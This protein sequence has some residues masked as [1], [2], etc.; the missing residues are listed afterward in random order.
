MKNFR[1]LITILVVA[2]SVTYQASAQAPGGVLADANHPSGA[3]GAPPASSIWHVDPLTGSLSVTI[4]FT[5]TP[6]GGRGPKIPFALK[7]NSSATVTLQE[8]GLEYVASSGGPDASFEAACITTTP[9]GT[10][11]VLDSS[12]E[13]APPSSSEVIGVYGWRAQPQSSVFGPTGPWITT[14]PFVTQ[15]ETS[16]V[17]QSY[18]VSADSVIETIDTG[19]GCTVAGPF[20]YTDEDGST[21]DMNLELQGT[22]ENNESSI[23]LNAYSLQTPASATF[24][25]SQLLTSTGSSIIGDTTV[26]GGSPALLYPDGTQVYSGSML[27][28]SNGNQATLGS[29]SEGRQAIKTTLPIGAAGLIPAGTY[30]VSTNNA[31]GLAETYTVQFAQIPI[32][33]FSMPHPLNT[34]LQN[35]GFCITAVT[36]PTS[37]AVSQEADVQSPQVDTTTGVTLIE[38]PDGTSYQFAYDPTYGTISTIS[39]PTGGYVRFEYQPRAVGNVNVGAV[40]SKSTLVVTDVYLSSGSG[41][42]SHWNYS[43]QNVT[44]GTTISSTETA[45]D[46][47]KTAYTGTPHIFSTIYRTGDPTWLET[48]RLI[49]DSNNNPMK[50]VT[51]TY[52]CG[53]SPT[54][55]LTTLY[56]GTSPVQQQVNLTYDKYCNVIEKDESDFFYTGAPPWLRKTFTTYQYVNSPTW[57]TAHIVNKP[58]QVVVTD[59]NGIP[60]S[61]TEYGYDGQSLTSNVTVGVMNHDDV[62]FGPSSPVLPRGNLTTESHCS[63]FTGSTVVLTSGTIP[64]A[65]GSALCSANSW[66]TTSRIYDITGQ[67][68]QVTDPKGNITKYDYTDHYTAFTP[69]KPTN[70]YP[71]TITHANGATDTYTYNYYIGGQASHTGWNGELTSYSYGGSTADPLN[72]VTQITS[73]VTLDATTNTSASA[74]TTFNYNDN[75]GAFQVTKANLVDAGGTAASSTTTYDGLG[76]VITT[77]TITPQC[78]TG[79]LVQTTYDALSRVAS[80]TNPFCST[81]DLTYGSTQFT[82][83]GLDRK[84]LVIN[85]DNSSTN[86]A[87]AGIAT[88]TTEPFNGTTNVQHIDQIDGLGRL[89]YVCEVAAGSLG[90]GSPGSCGLQM[91]GSGYLTAYNYDPLGNLLCVEQHGGVSGSSCSSSPS[92]DSTNPWH[93]RRFTYD[94]LSRLITAENPESGTISYSYPMQNSTACSGDVSAPCTKTDARGATTTFSYDGMNRLIGKSYSLASTHSITSISDLSACFNYDTALSGWSDGN[95]KGQITAAWEQPGNCPTTGVTAILAGAV[96]VRIFSSHDAMGRTDVEQECLTTASCSPSATTGV[97]AYSY[98]LMGEPVQ[99]NNGIYASAVSPT[100]TDHQNGSAANA[101]SLTWKATYDTAG[102]MQQAFVQDQPPSSVWAT[103]TYQANPTLLQANSTSAYDPFGHLVSAGI[104]IPYGSTA[105]AVQLNRQYDNRAR[106]VAEADAGSLATGATTGSVGVIT[107]NGTETGPWN[108]SATSGSAVLSVTGSEGSTEVCT[109]TT[110]YEGGNGQYPVQITT[111]NNVPNTGTLSVTID[112]FTATANYGGGTTDATIVAALVAGFGGMGSPVTATYATGANALTV[113]A[114]GT[115]P[116]TN[117]PITLS[118]GGGFSISDPKSTLVGGHAAGCAY[119]AGTITV[120]VTNNSVTPAVNYTTSPVSWGQT[121]TA[122]QLATSLLAAINT[123]AGSI[124]TASAGNDPGTINL[125][126]KTTGAGTNYTVSTI[127]NDTQTIA[128]PLYFASPSFQVDAQSMSGGNG[129][130]SSYGTIYAYAPTGG[131]A[132]NGNILEY[133]DTVMGT[134]SFTYDA[135][136]RLTSAKPG[137][138]APSG[139][140]NNIGCWSYDAYGNRTM[141]AF[142]TA[143]CNASPTPQT[144]NTFNAANSQLSSSTLSTATLTAGSV[145]YDGGGNVTFDGLNNYWYDAEGRL[146]A[147]QSNRGLGNWQYG[148]DAMGSRFVRGTPTTMPVALA[149][150][151]P[152][153]ASSFTSGSSFG[154]NKRYL[155]GLGSDQVTELNEGSSES[156]AHSIVR[157]GGRALGTYDT[158]GIHFALTDPLGTKRIE[159]NADGQIDEKCFSLPYGNDVNNPAGANC[160]AVANSLT[161][162]DATADEL[163]F[164]GKERD[165]ESGNDYF[166]ARYYA[167]T[168]GRWLS[169]DWSAK[170]EP[171]PYAKLDDPQTLN[172]YAYVTNNPLTRRDVDGHW[173]PWEHVEIS[174]WAYDRAGIKRNNSVI[175]AVRNV[176]GGGHNPYFAPIFHHGDFSRAQDAAGS[177]ADHFLRDKGQSQMA[178]YNASM[179]RIT[180]EANAAFAALHSGDQKAFADAMGGAGHAIQDSFAH[181]WRENGTGAITHLECYTCSGSE[182]DHQHPDFQPVETGGTIGPEAQASVDATADF[183]TLMNGAG[184][185]TQ[186]QFQG[187]LQSFEN[188]WFQQKLPQQ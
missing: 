13:A 148:Y 120:T 25:G 16:I 100:L 80:V 129:T 112:G 152:L 47:T 144:L 26:N 94:G 8:L 142:S 62:N 163:H 46:W 33:S 185:M 124:V 92:G 107:V 96:G 119:D 158:S 5:T 32:G 35:I 29:D 52:G 170:A 180:G 10:S 102:R 175:N 50:S 121:S 73:P 146:C 178:A 74:T 86:L 113:T 159:A 43:Y 109:T 36:C 20:L 79:V 161:S 188:K 60:K 15:G 169:P 125:V 89:K 84:T 67:L 63:S 64:T 30:S 38:R 17:D 19:Q 134:W 31:A 55:V 4:P 101:P 179:G 58:A 173:M 88:Q 171:V 65:S 68:Q 137:S 147:V 166:G 61:I 14:G 45:P 49:S 71:T 104:G 11:C 41:P 155:T 126:S 98:N 108:A 140:L 184:S 118:N 141:E 127:V 150:C 23:C 114:I 1:P 139:Y 27:E 168:M 176:D 164:T 77:S 136:D 81:T 12:G 103:S 59:G 78:S 76:R 157:L 115:G 165:S 187:G 85:P 149:S 34:E 116:S 40:I 37:F 110:V 154:F 28:D 39:F 160:S 72:R 90:S 138:N 75:T 162:G 186:S 51:T 53:P 131:Y 174:Q 18:T 93:I 182:M 95:P 97:F 66:L 82:Y 54:Q 135:A 117:Y 145:G 156:W 57:V 122:A 181:T 183:L 177:Q 167:S 91:S 56:G 87:Y 83:D 7:Y 22:W 42:E 128:Y 70:A 21:H 111:C 133:T 106:I 99:A 153:S 48:N 123:A 143:A 130:E 172:L 69:A 105:A 9:G 6:A 151:G 44:T 132:P 3:P 24:D 2:L